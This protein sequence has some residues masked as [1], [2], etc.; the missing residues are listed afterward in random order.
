MTAPARPHFAPIIQ[1]LVTEPNN[2]DV[3]DKQSDFRPLERAV[4]RHEVD[5]V[6]ALVQAGAEKNFLTR[7]SGRDM[8]ILDV[9][10]LVCSS[11]EFI[12][13]MVDMGFCFHDPAITPDYAI[14]FA[15]HKWVTIRACITLIGVWAKHRSLTLSIIDRG[16]LS[17]LLA[18]VWQ[19]RFQVPVKPVVVQNKKTRLL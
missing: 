4:L 8:T 13:D 18:E 6:R 15:R 5:M 17:L 1:W 7:W 14:D 2:F 12:I 16:A 11:K 3:N 9:A 19:N 10:M